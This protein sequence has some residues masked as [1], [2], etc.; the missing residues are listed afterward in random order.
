MVVG[1]WSFLTYYLQPET[2]SPITYSL[3]YTYLE[4]SDAK[5][6]QSL[7]ESATNSANVA[8]YVSNWAAYR[9]NMAAYT[10]K[11]AANGDSEVLITSILQIYII[12]NK[13]VFDRST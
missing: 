6:G 3:D 8:S 5:K 9:G 7:N 10:V 13:Y 2:T 11:E 1:L 12:K 4:D